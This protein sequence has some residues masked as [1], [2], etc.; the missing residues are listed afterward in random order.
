[1]PG[2]PTALL[3][4]VV[5]PLLQPGEELRVAA[6]VR[7]DPGVTEQVP[8][9]T[10]LA[11]LANPLGWFGADPHPGHLLRRL[12]WGY[13]VVGSERC[14]ARDL[15][16][17]VDELL[18]SSA[19][20]VTGKRLLIVG[21]RRTGRTVATEDGGYVT[22]DG[23]VAGEWSRAVLQAAVRTPRG[24]LRRGRFELA[25]GDG[26]RCALL[27]HWPPHAEPLVAELAAAWPS[28]TQ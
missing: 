21:L 19:L 24:V 10:E 2:D 12:T 1:M 16:G 15:Y 17:A 11:A 6:R 22:E 14:L 28:P 9:G 26:S 23:E 25:F 20:A 7:T 8:L 4:P 18:T 5:R 27:C 3:A 13:A